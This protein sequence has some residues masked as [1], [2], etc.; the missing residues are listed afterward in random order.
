MTR[1]GKGRRIISIVLAKY[2]N[3]VSLIFILY[4]LS[5]VGWLVPFASWSSSPSRSSSALRAMVPSA[6]PA[7]ISGAIVFLAP[8]RH[9]GSLWATDR[10]CLLLRAVR[11]VDQHLNAL[12]GPYPIFLLVARDNELDPLGKDAA[13]TSEDRS[14]LEKWAPR[15]KLIFVEIDMYSKEAL[16]PNTTVDQI[17]NW[18]AG[19][20]GAIKGRDLGY[21]SM[22]RLWSGRLQRMP[23]LENFDYYLRMDDDSLLLADFEWDP[24]LRMKS[25]GL[26]YAY[27][28]NA[29]DMWGIDELW[30]V[31]RPYIDL[32]RE[33]LPFAIRGD[34][35]EEK[36]DDERYSY[37]GEQP[38]NNFHISDL[39]F[40]RSSQWTNMIEDMDDRHLFFKYRVGDAN[41]HAMAIMMMEEKSFATWPETPYAHNSND[42]HDGWGQRGWQDECDSAVG[43]RTQKGS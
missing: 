21:Q 36:E 22:C 18:R 33:N 12:F 20:E 23:F 3:N 34:H 43:G 38:Y 4:L 28:R 35:D 8:Q 6:S 29:V 42:Y 26:T 14:L 30:K 1:K 10:F 2:R 37:Y 24:F 25:E 9:Q 41:V 15:S 11:S 27:R 5:V 32:Q 13:Y 31:A 7:D 16:E 39:S 40:W 19:N 17:T